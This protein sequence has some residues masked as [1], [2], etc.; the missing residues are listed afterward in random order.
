MYSGS[1]AATGTQSAG[2]AWSTAC[3]Q[4]RSRSGT[5]LASSCGR[6]KI[7][8]LVAEQTL[9]FSYL[10]I[11]CIGLVG[12][13]LLVYARPP[14]WLRRLVAARRHRIERRNYDALKV[15]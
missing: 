1:V 10:A 11:T 12:C 5:K 6:C 14:R 4:S 7:K 15:T 3:V 8:H 9:R 13:V 2:L